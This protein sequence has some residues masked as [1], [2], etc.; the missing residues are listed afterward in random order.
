MKDKRTAIIITG[1]IILCMVMVGL[2][3]LG[4]KPYAGIIFGCLVIFDIYNRI[5]NDN[6]IART[7]LYAFMWIMLL[8]SFFV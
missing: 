4:L 7:I 5:K 2:I 3:A 8:A 6:N 1:T